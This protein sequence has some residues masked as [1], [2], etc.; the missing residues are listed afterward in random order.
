MDIEDVDKIKG[1]KI[2]PYCN[3]VTKLVSG[4][5]VYPHR[6]LEIPRHKFLDKKYYVC[7]M[8]SDHYVGTYKDDKTSLGRLANL[9]LRKLKNKG[10]KIFDPLWKS[11]KIFKSQK[12][13]YKWL[14]EI[15]GI[16]TKFTHFGMFSEEQCE[17]AIYYCETIN[18]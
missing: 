6:T 13:A 9:E 5:Q 8:D 7:E 16:P 18:K 3:C 2:C 10:H 17:L 1:G 14:S 15:M 4:D 12:E 11:K